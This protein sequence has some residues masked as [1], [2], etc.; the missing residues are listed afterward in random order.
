M[1]ELRKFAWSCD[2][3]EFLELALRDWFVRG[4]ANSTMQKHLLSE[5]NLTLEQAVAL[6]MAKEMAVLESQ[7]SKE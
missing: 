6:A 2:F 7:E 3:G 4:L 5:K 1:I